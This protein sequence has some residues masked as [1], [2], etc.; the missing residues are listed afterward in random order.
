MRRFFGRAICLLLYLSVIIQ[1]SALFAPAHAEIIPEGEPSEGYAPLTLT[2]VSEVEW[3]EYEIESLSASAASAT[4]RA[5]TVEYY[6]RGALAALPNSTALLYAYD[7][8]VEGVGN[9]SEQF[10]IYNGTN[11]LSL[12][13]MDTV[14][15]AYRSDHTEQFWIGNSVRYSYSNSKQTVVDLLPSYIMTGSELEA[16]R[17]VFSQVV[18]S[19]LS[20]LPSGLGEFETEL[21]FH[22]KLA[23]RVTYVETDNAHNAYG[24]IVEGRAVCEGYAEALQYLLQLSGIQSFIAVGTGTTSTGIEAHA[25]NFVRID[26]KYY[27]TDLTWNDHG[28]N[29]FHAYFNLSDD[30]M[31]RDHTLSAV[32]YALPVCN[33][34]DAHY[35]SVKDGR[36]DGT[37]YSVSDVGN[38]LKEG[39]L[40]ASFYI[41]ED[42][43]AFVSWYYEN[44]RDIATAAGVS[45]TFT[46]GYSSVGREVLLQIYTCRH[47]SLTYIP[48]TPATCTTDGNS[49]AYYLCSCGKWFADRFATSEI[50]DKVAITL[51]AEGHNYTEKIKDA[52]HLRDLAQ[53]C[54]TPES[55]WF[56]CS[57]CDSNAKDDVYGYGKYYN[58]TVYGEHNM[59]SSWTSENGKHFHKCV[60]SGCSYTEDEAECSGGEATCLERAVCSVCLTEYGELAQHSYTDGICD[61]CGYG[62]SAETETTAADTDETDEIKAYSLDTKTVVII[63]V[64]AAGVVGVAITTA[65]IVLK[66]KE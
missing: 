22:D 20:E 3:G 55:Y 50:T 46:Y 42:V 45:G 12:E 48:A 21:Y 17:G 63:S 61:I 62:L 32:A 66:K 19:M 51:F 31:F 10:S 29:I 2:E 14:L 35:F 7:K 11:A 25:W 26:G 36:L 44:V 65:V 43:D 41:T 37:S 33:S 5:V 28:D 64:C 8:I 16:A 40:K 1:Y 56:D 54:Q 58:G 38:R 47:T 39:S 27:Q 52:E 57:R 60:V 23:E 6:G 59:S 53:D 18:E 4:E 24:A 49:Q 34:D 15:S 30:E 13:E 9:A